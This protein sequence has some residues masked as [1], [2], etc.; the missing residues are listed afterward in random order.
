LLQALNI[1]VVEDY[2]P[3]QSSLLETLQ[4]DGHHATGVDSAEAFD[5]EAQDHNLD[6]AIIDVTL[7]GEDGFSLAKRLSTV[8]PSLGIILLTARTAWRTKLPAMN[9][10]PICT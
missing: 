5:E 3:L 4:K 6:L 9:A 10:V 8:Q 7:P 2:L 1:L